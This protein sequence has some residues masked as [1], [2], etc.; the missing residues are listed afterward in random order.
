MP[1]TVRVD[2]RIA[3]VPRDIAA[4]EGRPIGKVIEDAIERYRHDAFWAGV[5]E[6]YARLRANPAAWDDYMNEMRLLEGGSL[7]G[8]EQEP[9]YYTPEEEAEIRA[10]HAK[11]FGR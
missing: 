2:N 11:T 1:T 7:D 3:A 9:P 10:E 8:L 4:A 6:D 5:Q